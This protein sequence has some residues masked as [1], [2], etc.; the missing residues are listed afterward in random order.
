MNGSAIAPGLL[1]ASLALALS[2]G[3]SNRVI[4]ISVVVLIATALAAGTSRIGSG[5]AGPVLAG[6]WISVPATVGCMF[7]S[8]PLGARITVPLCVNG[9]LWGGLAAAASARPIDLVPALFWVLLCLPA[10]WLVARG[11]GIAIKVAGSWLAAAA[12][13][14]LGLNMTS[15]LGYQPDHME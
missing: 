5:F 6:C 3:A 12:V 10:T 2:F 13:L 14:S 1:F 9:G 15:T 11:Q 8:R 4:A 7:L